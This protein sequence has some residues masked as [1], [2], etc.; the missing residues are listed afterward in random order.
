MQTNLNVS[1][2]CP[3]PNTLRKIKIFNPGNGI[4]N[5]LAKPRKTLGKFKYRTCTVGQKIEK[6]PI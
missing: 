1:Y 2:S 4:F 6:S 3:L 5:I